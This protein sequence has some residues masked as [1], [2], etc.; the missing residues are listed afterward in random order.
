MFCISTCWYT[1]K[2]EITN[3]EYLKIIRLLAKLKNKF[4]K[5]L[6]VYA[7]ELH[8]KKLIDELI[9]QNAD[10]NMLYQLIGKQNYVQ[11]EDVII[12]KACGKKLALNTKFCNFCGQKVK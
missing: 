1:S 7:A 9:K 3:I 12:C 11:T 10:V 4:G 6:L 5:T 8:N 2:D